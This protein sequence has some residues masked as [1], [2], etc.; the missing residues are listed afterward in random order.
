MTR[1]K[2]LPPY[3]NNV[4]TQRCSN[5]ANHDAKR[6]ALDLDLDRAFDLRR[7]V[8]H[9]GRNSIVIWGVNRQGCR[10]SR[11]APWMARGGAPPNQCRITGTPSL[12]EVPSGG[13]RAL[14][15]LWGFSKVS[16]CKSGT[17]SSRNLNNGYVLGLIP[18]PGRLTRRYRRQASPRFHRIGP[19]NQGRSNWQR[20]SSIRDRQAHPSR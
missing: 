4:S 9:A 19:V 16:R 2:C 7:P 11:P 10:F 12:G 5:H 15:L 3:Q 20:R 17:H 1:R 6:A 8:N 13:A 18:H 14:C